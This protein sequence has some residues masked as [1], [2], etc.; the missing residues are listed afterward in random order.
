MPASS[1]PLRS[2]RIFISSTFSDMMGERNELVLKIFPQIRQWCEARGITWTE[3]DLRW[4]VVVE[5]GEDTLQACLEE[6]DHCHPFFLGLI[7]QRY[8]S[9]HTTHKLSYTE[10]EI[11]RG[12]LEV[13]MQK[14]KKK[15]GLHAFF[16]FR[17]PALEP[18]PDPGDGKD[19]PES[20]VTQAALGARILASG[21]PCTTYD[22]LAG[23]GK[24]VHEDL[25]ARLNSLFPEDEAPTPAEYDV[26]HQK[27]R[28]DRQDQISPLAGNP[29]WINPLYA[30]TTRGKPVLLTGEEGSGKSVWLAWWVRHGHKGSACASVDA[31]LSQKLHAWIMRRPAPSPAQAPLCIYAAVGTTAFSSSWAGL[32]RSLAVAMKCDAGEVAAARELPNLLAAMDKKILQHL[33]HQY[34]ILAVD[35]VDQLPGDDLDSAV[36]WLTFLARLGAG[37]VLSSSPARVKPYAMERHWP[38]FSLPSLTV[39]DRTGMAKGY[40][41][42]YGKKL[43]DKN[44]EG[45]Q[46]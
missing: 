15:E 28:T 11:R 33:T 22:S 23:L 43:E 31:A 35:S 46:W 13:E 19:S 45:R 20:R 5:P 41:G 39:E 9:V 3:I 12:V 7:G 6:V 37:V 10:L 34:V 30:A 42:H 27:H 16:Y 38:V 44:S 26:R 1:I 40:L 36:S 2:V 18:P 29:D 17:D 8:G 14:K 21:H 32:A 4:G 25:I 24:Q